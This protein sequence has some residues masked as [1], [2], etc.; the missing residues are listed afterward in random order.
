MSD[1]KA[2]LIQMGISPFCDK[3]RRV[4]HYKGIAFS[5]Q[6]VQVAR[7]GTLRKLVPTGKVPILDYAGRRLYDST[8]IC[9]ELER[10]RPQPALL[11]ENPALRAEVLLLEDWADE[12]LYF[13]EMTMRFVWPDENQHWSRQLTRHDNALVRFLSPWLVPRLTR[14]VAG[15]QGTGRKSREQVLGDLRRLFGALQVR[16]ERNGYCVGEQLT[17]ADIAV[18]CQLHCITDVAAGRE[19]LEQFPLLAE[20]KTRVDVATRPHDSA[21]VH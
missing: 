13:F 2:V 3:V 1:D 18:A 16:I 15:H 6:E 12:S 5:T 7:L 8:D 10:L 4:L 14:T 17:L 21:E 20:W 11:P 19:L 9:L